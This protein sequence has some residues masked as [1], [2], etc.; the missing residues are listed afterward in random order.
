M[1]QHLLNE[2]EFNYFINERRGYHTRPTLQVFYG[3]NETA[4]EK[5]YIGC[6]IEMEAKDSYISNFDDICA[7]LSDA[8]NNKHHILFN[9]Y[10]SDSSLRN[11]GIECITLPFTKAFFE[12]NMED[13]AKLFE[14]A[15]AEGM[16]AH[17]SGRCGLHVHINKAALGATA[18]EIDK[19]IEKI[20]YFFEYYKEDLKNFSRRKCYDYAHFASERVATAKSIY[21]KI[22]DAKDDATSNG[23]HRAVNN[24]HA[25]TLEIRL[26]NSTLNAQTF[27]ATIQFIFSLIDTITKNDIEECSFYNVVNSAENA[28]LKEYLQKRNIII[29]KQKVK[30]LDLQYIKALNAAFDSLQRLELNTCKKLLPYYKKCAAAAKAEADDKYKTIT[31]INK[32]HLQKTIKNIG[33]SFFEEFT[34]DFNRIFVNIHKS[35]EDARCST[36]FGDY[37]YCLIDNIQNSTKL[38]KALGIDD[39]EDFLD[40]FD[41]AEYKKKINK[42]MEVM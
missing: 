41:I 42:L 9:Y 17:D 24:E 30:R 39:I 35:A 29:K 23:H 16:I 7:K 22:K 36:S 19:N 37:Y 21:A 11:G 6:E 26:F 33:N 5:T 10:N 3:K 4:D 8:F 31:K 40:A 15:K 13:F 20:I 14:I 1:I 2:D 27:F 28:A 12:E 18:A 25:N 32:K 38:Q 34:R